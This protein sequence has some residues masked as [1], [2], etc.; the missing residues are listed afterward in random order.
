M[1]GIVTLSSAAGARARSARCTLRVRNVFLLASCLLVCFWP[2][3]SAAQESSVGIQEYRLKAAFIYNFAKFTE[4]MKPETADSEGALLLCVAMDGRFMDAMSTLGSKLVNGRPLR[5]SV[6]PTLEKTSQSHILFINTIDQQVAARM[7][8]AVEGKGVLTVGE[9]AGFAEMGG[10]INFYKVA[11]KVRFEV[12]LDALKRSNV[13]LSSH[14][15]KLAR[16]VE[17]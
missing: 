7:L 8:R 6:C 2:S 4:W 1:G 12:N 3:A 15:L 11:N 13:R 5:V 17:E 9:M 14:V 10:I 16:I